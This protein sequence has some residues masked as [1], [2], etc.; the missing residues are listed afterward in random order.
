VRVENGKAVAGINGN[1]VDRTVVRDSCV[2]GGGIC[3]NYEG[4]S[5]GKE[6][7]KVGSGG[8]GVVCVVEGVDTS[9]C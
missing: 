5:D 1:F 6:P 3:W 7:K 2:V 9:G 4:N 8:D